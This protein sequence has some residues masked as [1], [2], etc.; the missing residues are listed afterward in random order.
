MKKIKVFSILA[1]TGAAIIGVALTSCSGNNS[2]K[3]AV[4]GIN[5]NDEVAKINECELIFKENSEIPYVSLEDGT[6]FLSGLRSVALKDNKYKV[7]YKKNGNEYVLSNEAGGTCTINKEKQTLTY[8]DYDKFT[9]IVPDTQKPISLLPVLNK[10]LKVVSN[11]YTAGKEVTFDLNG[12]S[13]LDIYEKD[14]KCY[15]PLSVYNSVLLNTCISM[16]LAYNGKDLFFMPGSVISKNNLEG[17]PELT[18]IGKKFY[19]GAA[20]DKISEEFMNYYYQSICF[21]FNCEYGLEGNYTN[22]DEFLNQYKYKEKILSTDPKQIDN[23][24][25]IALTWLGVK[26]DEHTALSE[27]SNMYKFRDNKIDTSQMNPVKVNHEEMDSKYKKAYQEAG[28]KTGYE[29]AKDKGTVFVT[30]DTF[31][32]TNEKLLYKKNKDSD[33]ELLSMSNTAC[34]FNELYKDLTSNTYKDTIKNI[35]VDVTAN[36]GG[37]AEGLLYSLSTLIGNVTVDTVNPVSGGHN[38]QVFKADIN[39]DGK[40][41]ADDKS[42]SE[43]GFN[44]YFLDSEY[45]FSSANAMPYLAKL[46]NPNVKTLGQKTAGGPCAVRSYVTPIGSVISSSSLCVIS[47]LENGKYVNIDDGI[48]ADYELT[49]EQMI[50]RMYILDNI[51]KWK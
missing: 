22:F 3:K 5:D 9:A 42:L 8:N 30:F 25:A 18:E 14:G 40:V 31:T 11:D 26:G 37:S 19:D 35:V 48:K 38:K 7:E 23:Y 15:L 46:N 34:L 12:Y 6:K 4:Y 13:L 44:I 1:L 2:S 28:I 10:S 50:D 43:L 21:D 17:E 27:T 33:D 29:F 20:K 24:T 41:D 47:K 16:N 51:D 36:D 49:E 45:S 39:A 32:D